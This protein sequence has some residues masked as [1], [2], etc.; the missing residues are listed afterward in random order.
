MKQKTKTLVNNWRD[1]INNQ[2]L[3]E[4]GFEHIFKQKTLSAWLCGI[5]NCNKKMFKDICSR[6]IGDSTLFS[7]NVSID[8]VNI[9][10]YRKSSEIFE[11]ISNNCKLM[12]KRDIIA[13][14]R[15]EM[16]LDDLPIIIVKNVGNFANKEKSKINIDDNID[17]IIHDLFHSFVDIPAVRDTF[18]RSI[19]KEFNKF[20][21]Q[22]K[23]G[24][25][26]SSFY[27]FDPEM[28]AQLE[29]DAITFLN[30][31]QYTSGVGNIDFYASLASYTIVNR[32][33]QFLNDEDLEGIVNKDEFIKI[34]DIIYKNSFNLFERFF[35]VMKNKIIC[36]NLPT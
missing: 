15:E 22:H 25:S 10:V 6:N 16:F 28:Y 4:R 31:K 2:I 35:S 9:I 18:D 8:L 14:H 13:N 34:Y 30:N 24:F 29:N 12:T 17:W 7:Q 1:Y 36:I 27:D 26:L 21:N 5:P 33:K 32:D 11:K 19:E 3:I 20:Y 23:A